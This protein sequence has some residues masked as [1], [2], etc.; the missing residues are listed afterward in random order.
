MAVSPELGQTEAGVQAHQ[1]QKP[2]PAQ[3]KSGY[4]E[5]VPAV[6]SP[7]LTLA[8][9]AARLGL[10]PARLRSFA[11]LGHLSHSCDEQGLYSF[12]EDAVAEFSRRMAE[13]PNR[14]AA[15][16]E[17]LLNEAYYDPDMDELAAMGL[18]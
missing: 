6:L 8:A 18:S 14:T 15:T 16:P 5:R 3:R 17:T 12:T 2:L 7:A 9:A 13:S 11:Q 1:F 10:E 4:E